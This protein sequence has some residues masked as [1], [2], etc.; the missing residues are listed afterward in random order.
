MAVVPDDGAS[1]TPETWR[2]EGPASAYVTVGRWICQEQH[3]QQ[4]LLTMSDTQGGRSVIYVLGSRREGE[5]QGEKERDLGGIA[6]L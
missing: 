2:Q 5:G 3:G 4:L 6:G 1:A